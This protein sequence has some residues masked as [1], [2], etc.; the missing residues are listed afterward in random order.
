MVAPIL[1]VL[2]RGSLKSSLLTDNT[3]KLMSQALYSVD[4][5]PPAQV[6][7]RLILVTF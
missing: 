2:S 7:A 4:A 3:L 5:K 6:P 1:Y